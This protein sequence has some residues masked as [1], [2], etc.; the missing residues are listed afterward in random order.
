V[1]FILFFIFFFFFFFFKEK[2][3]NGVGSGCWSFNR[4]FSHFFGV[5]ILKKK[6]TKGKKKK[7]II[8][9][10]ILEY[11]LYFGDF[12][13]GENKCGETCDGTK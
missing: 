1:C 11:I 9:L 4:C 2:E 8:V 7:N 5:S 3:G 13:N 10:K 12:K 6:E